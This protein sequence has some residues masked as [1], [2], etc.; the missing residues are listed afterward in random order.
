V[1]RKKDTCRHKADASVENAHSAT[2]FGIG[3]RVFGRAF[4]VEWSAHC[5]LSARETLATS[6]GKVARYP[7]SGRKPNCRCGVVWVN[8][9]CVDRDEYSDG[10]SKG[11]HQRP[12]VKRRFRKAIRIE[13]SFEQR[14]HTRSPIVRGTTSVNN[15]PHL[16]ANV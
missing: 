9:H 13:Y 15:R 10:D 12:Y 2:P 7:A 4:E 16:P 5:R 8:R 1:G 6:F 3:R 14:F 11:Y